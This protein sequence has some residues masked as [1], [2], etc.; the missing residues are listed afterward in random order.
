MTPLQTIRVAIRA[1]FRNK[2]RAFL[3]TLGVIIGVAAV[4]AMVAIGEG[5]KA[6]VQATFTSMG[7]NLLIVLPGSSS[8]GGV[9]VASAASPPSPGTTSTRSAPRWGR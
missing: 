2:M 3:T 6:R 8:G 4:I 5:A 7:S 9:R 1:L